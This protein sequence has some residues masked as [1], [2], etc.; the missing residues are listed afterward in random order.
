MPIMAISTASVR[1]VRSSVGM[2]C[3]NTADMESSTGVS[4][5]CATHSMEAQVPSRSGHTAFEFAMD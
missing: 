1:C 4:R 2:K 3:A 5:Q